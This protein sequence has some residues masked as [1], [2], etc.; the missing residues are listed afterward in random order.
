MSNNLH[1]LIYIIMYIY[2]FFF[3]PLPGRF[4]GDSF[5]LL[6]ALLGGFFEFFLVLV[7]GL[8]MLFNLTVHK[9][10]YIKC[11]IIGKK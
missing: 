5:L 1:L 8:D 9:Y 4:C 6:L 11:T 10:N 7:C 3:S 2:R